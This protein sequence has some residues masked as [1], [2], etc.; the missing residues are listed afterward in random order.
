MKKPKKITTQTLV[1]L[2]LK[3]TSKLLTF[4]VGAADMNELS[5]SEVVEHGCTTLLI[6]VIQP[7]VDATTRDGRVQVLQLRAQ[8]FVLV[9]V[10]LEWPGMDVICFVAGFLALIGVLR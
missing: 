10:K 8:D 5:P 2:A 6:L 1:P 9:F 7:D 3:E 4:A